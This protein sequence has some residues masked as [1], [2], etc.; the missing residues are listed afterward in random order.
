MRIMPGLA[1]S[2]P[3]LG[4]VHAGIEDWQDVVD[5]AFEDLVGVGVQANIR[6]LADVH[7]VEIVFVNV[8]DD[9]DI[10]KIGDG[11]GIGAEPDPARRTRW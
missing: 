7:G 2:M 10:R 4:G 3:N 11:E 9:P 8:A 6:G 1:T 5:S